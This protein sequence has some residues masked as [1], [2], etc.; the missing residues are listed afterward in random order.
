MAIQVQIDRG[1][2][3]AR[4]VLSRLPDGAWRARED[5]HLVISVETTGALPIATMAGERLPL[6]GVSR[7]ANG[8]VS[9]F[10]LVVLSFAGS[11]RIKLEA[12]GAMV[13]WVLVDVAPREDK[14]GQSAYREMLEELVKVSKDLPWGFSPADR[15]ASRD[16][17]SPPVV[18]PALLEVEL[19]ALLTTLRRICADPLSW[20]ERPRVLAPLPKNREIDPGT[21]RWL[22]EH[23]RALHVIQGDEEISTGDPQKT[24]VQQRERR[25]TR[26]HPAT[27]ALKC[28]LARLIRALR[29]SRDGLKKRSEPRARDLVAILERALGELHAILRAPAFRGVQAEPPDQTALLTLFDQPLYARAHKILHRLLDPGVRLSDEA[30]L[31]GSLR[32][33]YDLFELLVLYRLWARLAR[34]LG[35]AWEWMAPPLPPGGAIAGPANGTVFHARGPQGAELELH[36]QRTFQSWPSENGPTFWSL[37]RERR[38]DFILLLRHVGVPARWVLLD[39]KYRAS[40]DAVLEALGD[41]HIYR[42]S[43][44][45]NQTPAAAGFILVPSLQVKAQPFAESAYV[46]QHHFGALAVDSSDWP[47]RILGALDLVI[48]QGSTPVSAVA[49]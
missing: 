10:E 22:L 32:H 34:A 41:M 45:W 20:T 21:F 2:G 46:A 39:A 43:L 4:E 23:P 7:T 18:H 40:R 11:V 49:T 28:E 47:E 17:G 1:V 6:L 30:S 48:G 35:R 27:R 3:D 44:R 13:D 33:S 24:F 42:D 8:F 9:Q 31:V 19:P 12:D 16:S 15:G 26:N 36:F 25:L 38:P 5:D 37:S 29:S 14:L